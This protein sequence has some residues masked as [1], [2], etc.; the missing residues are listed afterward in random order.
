MIKVCLYP[1]SGE[2]VEVLGTSETEAAAWKDIIS[3]HPIYK[4]YNNG[5]FHRYWMTEGRT[6]IDFGS[7]N[8]YFTMEE[9]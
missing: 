6:Y 7:W 9:V 3:K 4:Q 8:Y 1:V 2:N 5:S